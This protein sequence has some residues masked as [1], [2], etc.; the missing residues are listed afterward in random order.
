MTMRTKCLV[1]QGSQDDQEGSSGV[2]FDGGVLGG[3]AWRG[4]VR[5]MA[6]TKKRRWA[7]GEEAEV[8]VQEEEAP[9]AKRRRMRGRVM[10]VEE[11]DGDSGEDV[12]GG[13]LASA[14]SSDSDGF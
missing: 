8:G 2:I 5:G 12:V 14:L 10:A 9:R 3:G 13:G 7:S 11:D 4:G 6:A 1:G